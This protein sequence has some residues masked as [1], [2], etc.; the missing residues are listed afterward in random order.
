MTES[1]RETDRQRERERARGV[2]S[3]CQRSF[4]WA[5]ERE[6]ERESVGVPSA[7]SPPAAAA[8]GAIGKTKR[9]LTEHYVRAFD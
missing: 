6:R 1:D 5:R 2:L 9:A 8:A 7:S 4:Y 3:S